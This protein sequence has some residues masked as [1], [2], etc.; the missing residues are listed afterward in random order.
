M[1]YGIF[2]VRT[3][4]NACDCTRGCTDTVKESALKVEF[5]RFFFFK[6]ASKN[7]WQSAEHAQL[8]LLL[9]FFFGGEDLF[10]AL[11][12]ALVSHQRGRDHNFFV[13]NISRR[14]C[15]TKMNVIIFA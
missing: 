12:I 13:R 1:D 5:R 6:S 15:M 7:F 3:N 4:V 14:D 11:K 9:F 2:N 10:C 8:F